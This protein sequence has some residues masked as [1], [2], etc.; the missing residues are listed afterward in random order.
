MARTLDEEAFEKFSANLVNGLAKA[1]S[2]AP[3]PAVS[4]AH[5]GGEDVLG[6]LLAE[7]GLG[8]A[9]NHVKLSFGNSR[10]SLYCRA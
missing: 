9:G 6:R 2:S 4:K 1:E 3:L 5:S 8:L 7:R 10:S